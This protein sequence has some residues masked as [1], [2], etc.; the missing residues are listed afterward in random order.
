MIA[1]VDLVLLGLLTS[2]AILLWE[3]HKQRDNLIKFQEAL[4][5]TMERHNDLADAVVDLEEDVEEIKGAIE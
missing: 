1:V 5:E 3:Q 4:L 2:V